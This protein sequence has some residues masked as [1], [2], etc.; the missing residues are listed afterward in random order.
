[1]DRP[2]DT[3]WQCFFVEARKGV[4][5][6]ERGGKKVEARKTLTTKLQRAQRERQELGL[7]FYPIFTPAFFLCDSVVN[8]IAFLRGLCGFAVN[9]L[10]SY[11]R[12][13]AVVPGL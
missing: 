12:A 3:T 8:V 5:R 11:H 9:L 7:G 13:P 1:M 10:A 2:P 6:G 4:H